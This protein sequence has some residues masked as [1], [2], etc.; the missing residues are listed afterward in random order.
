MESASVALPEIYRI[1]QQPPGTTSAPSNSSNTDFSRP[2][3]ISESS[4]FP[5]AHMVAPFWMKFSTRLLSRQ[6]LPPSSQT[7]TF[8][9][10]PIGWKSYQN[11]PVWCIF[12]QYAYPSSPPRF[13]E[14]R[15]QFA[16]DFAKQFSITSV[17]PSG[18]RSRGVSIRS[19]SP[20]LRQ[21]TSPS[22]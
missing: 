14:H 9:S 7:Y 8:C 17:T 2:E 4:G 21:N 6:E 22:T 13:S 20:S 11:R 3:R 1:R 5:G 10:H 16:T 18:P 12:I 19:L 15:F